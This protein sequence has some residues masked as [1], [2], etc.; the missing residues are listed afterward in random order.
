MIEIK[1]RETYDYLNALYSQ[2]SNTDGVIALLKNPYRIDAVF[3]AS[4]L[5]DAAAWIDESNPSYIKVALLDSGKIA[6][7]GVGGNDAVKTVVAIQLDVD[8][9]KDGF[10]SRDEAIDALNAMPRPPS[11]LVNTNGESGGFHAYWILS[12]PVRIDSKHQRDSLAA[13]S[14]AWENRLRE[15]YGKLDATSDLAR[16]LR[17]VG[18]TRESGEPVSIAWHNEDARYT[19]DEL[20]L[21]VDEPARFDAPM[22]IDYC[23]SSGSEFM[24][25]PESPRILAGIMDRLGYKVWQVADGSW[26]FNRPGSMHKTFNGKIGGEVSSAGN[27]QLISWTP[28]TPFPANESITVFQAYADLCHGSDL[29]RAASA[30]YDEGF[31]ETGESVDQVEIGVDKLIAN[32]SFVTPVQE[33]PRPAVATAKVG[34]DNIDP[35][36]MELMDDGCW[37]GQT[38]RW[39]LANQTIEL[40]EL[41]FA[42][43]IH[44]IGLGC[45]RVWR[46][47][48]NHQTAANMYLLSVAPTGSGKEMPRKCAKVFLE[49]AGY[50]HL[51][52]PDKLSSGPGLDWTVAQNKT[53]GAMPDEVGDLIEQMCSPR[54]AEYTASISQSLKIL[55]TASSSGHWQGSCRVADEIEGVSYPHLNFWGSTTPS[56]FFSSMSADKIT[57]GLIG[58]FTMLYASITKADVIA[59]FAKEDDMQFIPPSHALLESW[60]RVKMHES[61]NNKMLAAFT[62]SPETGESDDDEMDERVIWNV[63]SRSKEAKERF[64][65]HDLKIRLKNIDH[66]EQMQD[67]ETSVWSRANEKTAKLALLYA[68]SRWAMEETSSPPVITLADMDR[69]VKLSNFLARRL[70]KSIKTQVHDSTADADVVE[71]LTVIA[72]KQGS[73]DSVRSSDIYRVNPLKKLKAANRDKQL[74][75][76]MQIQGYLVTNQSQSQGGGLAFSITQDG[77][78]K[79]ENGE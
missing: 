18:T 22:H 14:K 34:S 42:T 41:A 4:E 45:A 57:D 11:M 49:E 47:D 52:G 35:I 7:G 53:V 25:S 9:N 24:K 78:E 56:K 61:P 38:I 43:A 79:L 37:I 30:L 73:K 55:Y 75:E 39:V 16:M 71:L 60:R 1:A 74:L 70:I 62:A 15:K 28:N 33:Q 51:C 66:E 3:T 17:P 20:T 65:D 44:L 23:E 68:M 19:L 26:R 46:D 8:A 40:P 72:K 10:G 21:E 36:P 77:I 31:G 32:A 5:H 29:S 63:V 59:A 54:A 76:L 48:S 6:D 69:A 50:Q 64:R 58:R 12:E 2:C 13:I 27:H 67:V